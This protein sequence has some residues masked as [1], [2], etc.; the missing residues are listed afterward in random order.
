MAASILN[1]KNVNRFN[2]R[3]DG[4]ESM[5]LMSKYFSFSCFNYDIVFCITNYRIHLIF[6]FNIFQISNLDFVNRN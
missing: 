1:V 4:F 6:M 3:E 2:I 5:L